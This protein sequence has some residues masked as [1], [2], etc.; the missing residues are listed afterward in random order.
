MLPW[1]L[2]QPS[3]HEIGYYYYEKKIFNVVRLEEPPRDRP[4][5]Y[6]LADDS[7]IHDLY[8][9]IYGTFFSGKRNSQ[10]SKRFSYFVGKLKIPE[11]SNKK[12]TMTNTARDGR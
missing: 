8:K 4:V 12:K 2:R 10:R 3:K 9:Q 1:L 5:L 6:L 7:L 11:D